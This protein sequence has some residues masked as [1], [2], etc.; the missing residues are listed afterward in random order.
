MYE[1]NGWWAPWCASVN[2]NSAAEFLAAWRHIVDI[3]R[4]KGATNIRWIWAPNVDNDGLGV[5]FA[6]LYPGDDYVDWVGLDGFNRG[7]SWTSTTWVGLHRIFDGSIAR[8]REL[9]DKP[10]LIAETGSSE[11]GG[12][13]AAWIRSLADIPAEFPE[14]RAIVWFSKNETSL[15][16][17]WRVNSSEEALAAFR[18]IATSPAFAGE[19]P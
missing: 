6:E 19:L 17:D 14:V 8:L 11:E 12:E 3:A 7:T 16:I 9:T 1:M 18:E 5:P 13:K 15:G 10:L 2:G 4:A